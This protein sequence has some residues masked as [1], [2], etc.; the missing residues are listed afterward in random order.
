MSYK[1]HPEIIT[2]TSTGTSIPVMVV[3]TT[4]RPYYFDQ[5]SW[6]EYGHIDELEHYSQIGWITEDFHTY[7]KIDH[8]EKGEMFTPEYQEEYRIYIYQAFPFV[9]AR[10]ERR[11]GLKGK[12][13]HTIIY[14]EDLSQIGKTWDE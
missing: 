8:S 7:V 6:L 9:I 1:M 4:V 11:E 5:P 13:T 10:A 14:A 12:V 2:D 3:E